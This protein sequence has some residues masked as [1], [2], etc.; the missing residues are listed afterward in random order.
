MI[1][2]LDDNVDVVWKKKKISFL[3]KGIYGFFF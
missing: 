2:I 1:I 3:E